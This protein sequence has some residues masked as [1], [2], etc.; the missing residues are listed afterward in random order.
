MSNQQRDAEIRAV[1]EARRADDV[2][3]MQK[4]NAV[5]RDAFHARFPG[6]IVHNMRLI[7]KRLQ[8]LVNEHEGINLY[9]PESWLAQPEEIRSLCEALWY[10]EQ[11]RL[12]WPEE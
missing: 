10:L 7:N 9:D 8:H 11:V 4:V 1:V 6:A 3:L 2:K 5:H 12:N